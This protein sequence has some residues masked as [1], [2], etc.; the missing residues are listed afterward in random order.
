MS[1]HEFLHSP[2][3][4]HIPD[5]VLA[6]M[7]RQ[8]FDLV[9]RRLKEIAHSC[10]A[11]LAGVFRTK[12]RIFIY[13]ANGH[14]GWE[15]ALANICAPGD[16]VLI[17]EV[18]HFSNNWAD[19]A[20]ALGLDVASLEGDWR[21][22]IDPN[23]IERTLRRD[24]GRRIKAVLAVQVDT[25]TG[26]ASDV[27]AVREAIDAAGHPALLVADTIASLA[28]MPFDM[29]AWGVDVAIAASQKALMCPPG[30]AILAANDKA[31]RT[32]AS[33]PRQHRYWDWKTRMAE[34]NYRAFCGTMPEQ[35][36]FGLRAALDMI[37][38]E[39]LPAIFARHRRLAGAVHRALEV[40]SEAGALSFNAAL[41]EQ[42]AVTVTAV[43]TGEGI[44]ADLIRKHTRETLGVAVAGGLGRLS[45]H[46]FRIGHL[47]DLNEPMVLGCLAGLE[48][49]FLQLGV[50][51][52]PGGVRA[53]IEFLAREAG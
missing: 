34:E 38:E 6:A 11:D 9:D 8:P 41:P 47:G 17:P 50:P 42:R 46:A 30:L 21:H 13:A 2:G 4:T 23:D 45:G 10:F 7:H 19:H 28:A 35:L 16:A 32:A 51:H 26:V 24:T 49:A 44:D 29:D 33:V 37:G 3:P 1:G 39:G 53:A 12:G 25:G 22:A 27:K 5:R 18:G 52:A 20:R 40:W 48:V 43:R 15:A 14:G 36:V 31:I